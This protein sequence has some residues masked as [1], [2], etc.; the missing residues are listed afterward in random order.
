M[1]LAAEALLDGEAEELTRKAIE[2]AKAGDGAALRLC[3]ERILPA[4]RDR[5]I[6]FELPAIETAGDAS[7]AMSAILRV[8]A[9]GAISPS[10]GQ[11]VAGLL[12]GFVKTLEATEFEKRLAALEGR[13]VK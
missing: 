1:T 6:A 13:P 2:L 8:V 10:E 7:R 11:A 4:R 12:E 9:D 3:L 5:P